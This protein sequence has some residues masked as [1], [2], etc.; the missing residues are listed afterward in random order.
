MNRLLL[1]LMLLMLL[2]S[3][4]TPS[5]SAADV[6]LSGFDKLLL[7]LDPTAAASGALGTRYEMGLDVAPA[8]PVRFYPAH[9]LLDPTIGTFSPDPTEPG[10]IAVQVPG[11]AAGRLLY[12]EKGRVDDLDPQEWLRTT[13]AGTP[14]YLG[15][16]T[17]VPVVRERDF[18]TGP[19]VFAKVPSPYVYLDDQVVRTGYAQY[20]N[21]LRLYDVDN[22]GDVVVRVRIS[23]L[24][25]GIPETLSDTVVT[26]SRREGS[27]PSQP[28][29]AE[30][31]ID[32]IC[33]PFSQHTPC[34]G[35]TMRITVES[36]TTGAR[37]WAMLSLTNNFTQE[38]TLFWPQ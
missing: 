36:M 13:P 24:A 33:H 21:L 11:S 3:L 22:R 2:A 25:F 5:A 10:E 23:D 14:G 28:Y 20:R 18:R 17:A 31:P 12:V 7:P 37:Y 26:L 15:H 34:A 16:W 8:S 19:I 30:L 32:P 27:D 29:H 6:D 9:S 35:G 4:V 38:V 1:L